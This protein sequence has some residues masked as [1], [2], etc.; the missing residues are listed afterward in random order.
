MY[1]K[2]EEEYQQAL[3]AMQEYQERGMLELSSEERIKYNEMLSAVA[4]YQNLHD[5]V[6]EGQWAFS[7]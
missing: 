4:W 6:I 2:S 1:I 5:P 7:F 3:T